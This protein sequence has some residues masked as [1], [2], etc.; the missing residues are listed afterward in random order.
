MYPSH[1]TQHGS[2]RICCS[3]RNEIVLLLEKT[4][5]SDVCI[6]RERLGRIGGIK[7]ANGAR[8]YSLAVLSFSYFWTA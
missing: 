2:V 1:A 3:T 7:M 6:A 5:D 8:A 4:K